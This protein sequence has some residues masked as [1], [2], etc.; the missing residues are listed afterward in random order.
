MSSNV[1]RLK[2][3]FEEAVSSASGERDAFLREACAG[4]T[5]LHNELSSLLEAYDASSGFFEK[6]AEDLIVPAFTAPE[7]DHEDATGPDRNVSHY[8]ILERI[9]GGG[10]GVV[11]KARDTRLGRTVALKFLHRRQASNPGAQDR[12][13]AETRAVSALDH[14]NIAVAYEI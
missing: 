7:L 10:M 2:Q 11:Y 4:D 13:L 1:I 5:A 14:P 8:A 6:L 12:I 9:G 3:L